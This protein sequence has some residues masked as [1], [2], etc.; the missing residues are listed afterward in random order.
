[1]RDIEFAPLYKD[2]TLT[3]QEKC[4]KCISVYKTPNKFCTI[5]KQ[6]ELDIRTI[7][8]SMFFFFFFYQTMSLIPSLS[9]LTHGK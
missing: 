6:L 5:C 4:T 2:I 3:I 1:M 7:S 9:K 8:N